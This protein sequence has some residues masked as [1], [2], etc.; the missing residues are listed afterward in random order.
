MST[1]KSPTGSVSAQPHLH[2][3]EIQAYGTVNH[4]LPVDLEEPVRLE[5]AERLNQL[6]AD[7]MTIRDLY[8]VWRI[9]SCGEATFRIVQMMNWRPCHG[10][11]PPIP[12]LCRALPGVGSSQRDERKRSIPPA[13]QAKQRI[14]D[15]GSDDR[16]RRFAAAAWRFSARHDV[17]VD[18]DWRVL[19]VR[20]REVWKA[21]FAEPAK[22]IRKR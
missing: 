22:W 2:Q 17:H 18:G 3:R 21:R 11:G 4:A 7:T 13:S 16:H 10:Q 15:G 20:R 19:H 9:R 6:L 12:E 1:K 8:R 5:I 14:G